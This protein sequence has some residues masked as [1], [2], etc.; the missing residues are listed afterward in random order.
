[1]NCDNVN[2]NAVQSDDTSPKVSK[3]PSNVC[4]ITESKSQ[5][6]EDTGNLKAILAEGTTRYKVLIKEDDPVNL[7]QTIP[8]EKEH[9][10]PDQDKTYE[11]PALTEEIT[12]YTGEDNTCQDLPKQESHDHGESSKMSK[13]KPKEN[14]SDYEELDECRREVEDPHVYQELVKAR[15]V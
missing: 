12:G 10:T 11:L 3:I 7:T 14:L 4:D 8:E 6:K 2:S 13:A 5:A 9:K 15:V 1:M